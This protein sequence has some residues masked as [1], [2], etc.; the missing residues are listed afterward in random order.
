MN[1][2]IPSTPMRSGSNKKVARPPPITPISH[3]NHDD[4]SFRHERTCELHPENGFPWDRM[5][6]ENPTRAITP[7]G[8]SCSFEHWEQESG[9]LLQ[10]NRIHSLPP[11]PSSLTGSYSDERCPRTPRFWPRDHWDLPR[12]RVPQVRLGNPDADVSS[13]PFTLN[14]EPGVN[15]SD[16]IDNECH[17]DY[18]DVQDFAGR[19]CKRIRFIVEWPCYSSVTKYIWVERNNR[20]L[21]RLEIVRSIG[22]ILSGFCKDASNVKPTPGW[23][24]WRIGATGIKFEDI[25]ISS[26]H[27]IEKSIWVAQWQVVLPQVSAMTL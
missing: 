12:V 24:N 14:D 8:C 15:L 19:D 9:R 22:S 18:R 23:A 16:V 25:W 27:C 21:T 26:L 7:V 4:Y 5:N 10:R 13:I 17:L 6:D 1:N 3:S 20:P 2:T 11:T